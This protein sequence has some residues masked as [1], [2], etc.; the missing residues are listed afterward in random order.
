MKLIGA[1]DA[2][3]WSDFRFMVF[4]HPEP[5]ISTPTD[6]S[7]LPNDSA[8]EQVKASLVEEITTNSTSGVDPIDIKS[9]LSNLS[10]VERYERLTH[11]SS[12]HPFVV[13]TPQVACIGLVNIL[14]R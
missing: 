12:Q 11:L 14:L 5:L 1:S 8:E 6:A 7:S 13:L 4:D 3:E 2:T 9:V 10:F